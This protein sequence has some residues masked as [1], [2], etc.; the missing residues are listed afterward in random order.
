M[1]ADP[2]YRYDGEVAPG[3]PVARVVSIVRGRAPTT[4]G[5]CEDAGEIS[6]AVRDDSVRGYYG[7]EFRQ[8]S[9]YSPDAIFP[10]GT[11]FGGPMDGELLFVFYWLDLPHKDRRQI[12]LV[13][14]ITPVTRSGLV[15]A[16]T[17]LRVVESGL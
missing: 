11:Y 2:S 8:V 17:E 12:D 16:P 6:I 5:S 10:S 15:G 13:V 3:A 9:G 7:Y 4:P 1:D 14:R